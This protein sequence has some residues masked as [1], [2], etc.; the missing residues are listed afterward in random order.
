MFIFIS[1]YAFCSWVDKTKTLCNVSVNS[2]NISSTTT[3]SHCYKTRQD[4]SKCI[5]VW[6]EGFLYKVVPPE[7]KISPIMYFVIHNCCAIR[8]KLWKSNF[9]LYKIN[10]FDNNQ[11]RQT[12]VK[13]AQRFSIFWITIVDDK[14]HNWWNFLLRRN[15]FV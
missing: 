14:I 12:G 9:W 5:T 4:I 11:H 6:S 1:L 8:A 15:N 13:M 2:R 3:Q 10:C 7:L